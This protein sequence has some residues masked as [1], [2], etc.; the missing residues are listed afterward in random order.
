MSN[1]PPI[2]DFRLILLKLSN[3]IPSHVFIMISDKI[4]GPNNPSNIPTGSTLDTTPIIK[5]LPSRGI[6]WYSSVDF[7]R[8]TTL[9]GNTWYDVIFNIDPNLSDKVPLYLNATASGDSGVD[10][11]TVEQTVGVSTRTFSVKGY[12]ITGDR[13]PV[14]QFVLDVREFI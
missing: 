10:R 13:V 11:Y 2:F 12:T 8:N 3:L 14:T 7:K 6:K 9:T 4:G 5:V 1:D